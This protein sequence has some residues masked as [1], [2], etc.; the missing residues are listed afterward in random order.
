MCFWSKSIR[1]IC[2]YTMLNSQCC[3]A[4][5]MQKKSKPSSESKTIIP[6]IFNSS[7]KYS[8]L[9]DI[10][11]Y[12]SMPGCYVFLIKIPQ[13]FKIQHWK[14]FA[15]FVSDPWICTSWKVKN[16]WVQLTTWI[17]MNVS[18]LHSTM[19]RPRQMEQKTALYKCTAFFLDAHYYQTTSTIY[20]IFI[21]WILIVTDNNTEHSAIEINKRKQKREHDILYRC[22]KSTLPSIHDFNGH[23]K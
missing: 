19:H 17:K 7:K 14:S 4:I 20:G 3:N 1:G 10:R 5:Q 12:A 6:L 8:D 15:S 9:F 18:L 2:T 11:C 21:C 22:R 16:V 13:W 23:S